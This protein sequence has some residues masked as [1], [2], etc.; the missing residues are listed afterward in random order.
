MTG[1]VFPTRAPTGNMALWDELLWLQVGFE[2]VFKRIWFLVEDGLSL[3]MVLSDFLSR[4]ITPLQSC[5][6]AAWQYTGEGDTTWLERSQRSN[7]AL[8]VPMALL[9]KLSPDPSS[10]DFTVLPPICVPLCSDQA[11]RSR[12]LQELP[13]LDNTDITVWQKGDEYRGVPIPEVD[14][15]SG[16][17]ALSASPSCS[18]G[19]GKA[20]APVH[21]DDEVS[22]HDDHPPS[23]EEVAPHQ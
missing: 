16:L 11:M 20:A 12:L 1:L 9:G 6:R 8:N 23:E 5:V 19:K 14:V 17:G 22:S 13:T 4:C 18:K 21:S 7:L 15:A 3:M 2:P 10:A